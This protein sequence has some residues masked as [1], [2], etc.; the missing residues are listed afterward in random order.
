MP[1]FGSWLSS[2]GSGA[3][4]VG[5]RAVAAAAAAAVI[6]A[7]PSAAPS[8]ITFTDVTAKAGITFTHNSGRAG[9]KFLPETLGSGAAF[10]D[11][12]GDGWPDIVL[13]NS[14]DWTPKGRRSLS[15]LYRNNGNGTFTNIT[16]GSGLDVEMYAIGV[17]VG[18]YDNDG[19]DDIYI[20][21]LEGDRL[22]H[23]EG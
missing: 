1:G 6:G 22:F 12:D 15:A 10:I 16:A 18:D 21:A 5:V 9:K 23:N 7:V 8:G 20:T 17:A 13:V 2:I 3:A 19:R 11:A 14:K 4:T